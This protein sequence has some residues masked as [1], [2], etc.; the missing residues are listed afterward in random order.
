M[1]QVEEGAEA[2]ALA[3]LKQVNLVLWEPPEVQYDRNM[4]HKESSIRAEV[5]RSRPGPAGPAEN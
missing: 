5:A 3:N 4:A 2:K 1:F